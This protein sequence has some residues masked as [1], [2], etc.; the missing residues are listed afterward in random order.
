MVVPVG[1][2]SQQ[3]TIVTKNTGGVTESRTI[4]VLFVPMVDPR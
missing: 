4:R 2:D 3:M 1:R